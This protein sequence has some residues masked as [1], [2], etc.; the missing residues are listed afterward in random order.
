[1][2]KLAKLAVLVCTGL[3]SAA[4]AKSLEG[5]VT[6]E[7]GKPISNATVQIVDFRYANTH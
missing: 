3:S 5:I 6:R 2:R 1:M 7:D 4:I